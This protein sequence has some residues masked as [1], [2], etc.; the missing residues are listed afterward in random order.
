ML[1]AHIRHFHNKAVCKVPLAIASNDPLSLFVFG[2]HATCTSDQRTIVYY[3]T[4]L[5]DSGKD[6]I[7]CDWN[8]KCSINSPS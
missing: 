6:K 2:C 4:G 8:L 3:E 5:S 1:M 7:R